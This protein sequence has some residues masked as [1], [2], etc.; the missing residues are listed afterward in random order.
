MPPLHVGH[1]VTDPVPSSRA[2][3]FVHQS[4]PTLQH[5]PQPAA[6]TAATKRQKKERRVHVFKGMSTALS[7]ALIKEDIRRVLFHLNKASDP[8]TKPKIFA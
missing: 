6:A 5:V 8:A 1:P 7:Q 3:W 4:A 2:P